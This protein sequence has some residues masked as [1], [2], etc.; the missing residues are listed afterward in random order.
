MEHA[1]PSS[2]E[3]QDSILTRFAIEDDSQGP[4][5]AR[6][7]LE[8]VLVDCFA[9]MPG[10]ATSSAYSPILL[11]PLPTEP[12]MKAKA[13][14]A[15]SKKN[16]EG[17]ARGEDTLNQERV[18]QASRELRQR[19][20]HPRQWHDILPASVEIRP[21]SDQ[22]EVVRWADLTRAQLRC[23]SDTNEQ[24]IPGRLQIND[25]NEEKIIGVDVQVEGEEP[26]RRVDVLVPKRSAFLLTDLL[27]KGRDMPIGW[28]SLQEYVQKQGG[29]DLLVIDPPYPNHSAERLSGQST[30]K[31][32]NREDDTEPAPKNRHEG[33]ET[34][35]LYDLWTLKTPVRE[36]LH[37]GG[38]RRGTLVAVWVTHSPKAK[39]FVLDK[40]FPAWH[41]CFLQEALWL[42][43]L[44]SSSSPGV[45][46][47]ILETQRGCEP[48]YEDGCDRK[49][50]EV[51]LLGRFEGKV[52]DA[53]GMEQVPFSDFAGK[54]R[55]KQGSSRRGPVE[56]SS[57]ARNDVG[58]WF[59]TDP[60]EARR[61]VI[62]SVPIGHSTKPYLA[63]ALAN[64]QPHKM[65]ER[66][67]CNVVELF[68]RGILP[69][70]GNGVYVGVGNEAIKRN[71]VGFGV[72]DNASVSG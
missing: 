14:K 62:A 69:G 65:D 37:A 3:K 27:P 63:G 54:A 59:W 55:P 57:S 42:K 10:Y 40:L 47:S 36:L 72:R 6:T 17:G 9:S 61:M 31:R 29:V 21:V 41:V 39:R 44:A 2:N 66:S 15:S 46:D 45:T 11:R 5:E 35:D 1:Q 20:E 67:K 30:R 4:S 32:K 50:Y 53:S 22:A 64:L 18:L 49:P 28:T 33:Y 60:V 56:A 70:E 16:S 51:L 38:M 8:C 48:V 19:W 71:V 23:S 26:G 25:D 13:P 34:V 12:W 7:T 52:D 68:A 43:V 24:L 58:P